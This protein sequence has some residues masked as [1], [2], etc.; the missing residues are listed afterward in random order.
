MGACAD[1]L[2]AVDWGAGWEAGVGVLVGGSGSVGV[3]EGE[4]NVGEGEAASTG[5][6]EVAVGEGAWVRVGART[7]GAWEVF[8][9]WTADA[10]V[11]AVELGS[12]AVLVLAGGR[13]ADP[14]MVTSGG[15]SVFT[16]ETEQPAMKKPNNSREI[17]DTL[18]F[19]YIPTQTSQNQW[20]KGLA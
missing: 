8:C 13:G 4:G 11:G 7:T 20:R 5:A 14:E 16:P 3:A 18:T 9:A 12:A 17:N 2:V 1:A 6:V 15:G 10:P 19:I